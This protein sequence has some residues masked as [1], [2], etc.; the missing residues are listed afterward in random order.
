MSDTLE[1]GLA[2]AALYCTLPCFVVSVFCGFMIGC[3]Y[4]CRYMYIQYVYSIFSVT[5]EGFMSY[6][7]FQAS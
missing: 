7:L 5:V 3:M 2:L 1:P 6:L 4:G